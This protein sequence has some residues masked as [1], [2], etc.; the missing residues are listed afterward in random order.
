MNDDRE[1]DTFGIPLHAFGDSVPAG[2]FEV[3]GRIVAVNAQIE[4]L[5]DRLDH[6]PPSETDGVRKAEQFRARCASG[7][8]DRN[9]IVHSRWVFGAQT[10]RPDI[11]LGVR[12]KTRRQASGEIATVSLSDVPGSERQQD[13]VQHTLDALKKLLRRDVAT[14]RI[15]ELAYSEIMLKWAVRQVDPAESDE[16]LP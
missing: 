6:L 15:G 8:A 14:M 12:Y 11:I 2:F 4:Y 9:A 10:A 13:T 16:P 3:L 5:Q 7:R 1:V